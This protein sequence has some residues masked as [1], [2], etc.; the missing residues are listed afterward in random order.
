MAQAGNSAVANLAGGSAAGGLAALALTFGERFEA[1]GSEAGFLRER[2][3]DAYAR[4]RRAGLPTRRQEGWRFDDLDDLSAGP[5][6]RRATAA[7]AADIAAVEA[8]LPPSPGA[9]AL[10]LVFVNGVFQPALSCRDN[11]SPA[12]EYGAGVTVAPLSEV[13]V[14]HPEPLETWLDRLPGLDPHP[15]VALNGAFWRDGVAMILPPGV[16][17]ERPLHLVHVGYGAGLVSFPRTLLVLGRGARASVVEEYLQLDGIGG[18]D[19]AADPDGNRDGNRNG[20]AGRAVSLCCPLTEIDLDRDSALAYYRLQRG[21][22]RAF[23]LGGLR[24]RLGRDARADGHCVSAGGRANRVD[25]AATLN[26]PGADCGLRGLSL[27]EDGELSDFHVHVRHA[28]PH[29]S[30]RQ[31]FRGVL[32]GRSRV[33]FDGLIDVAEGAQKTDASQNNRNLLLGK[34]A[35]AHSIPRLEILADDVQCAHGSTVGF[36][37]PDALFYLR[38]RGIAAPEARAMLVYAFANEQIEPVGLQP[39]RERLT[40][41]LA[42]RFR[43]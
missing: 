14:R 30:S 10:R 15:F 7:D 32:D 9:D 11:A 18:E 5:A 8:A 31:V 41:M 37:D 39:L 35:L 2:R 1:P 42:E 12:P 3:A 13:L 17:L 20:D 24:L 22:P 21:G 29:G 36:L 19:Q 16:M 23:N 4:F 40:A 33:V 26:G 25:I 6:L 38:S 43:R 27:V 28:E 34:R